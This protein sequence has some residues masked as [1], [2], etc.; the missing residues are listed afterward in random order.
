ML[1][2]M[3]HSVKNLEELLPDSSLSLDATSTQASEVVDRLDTI[4]SKRALEP[5]QQVEE[6][7]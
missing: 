7:G 2:Y 3:N 1:H 4:A 6:S 5:L